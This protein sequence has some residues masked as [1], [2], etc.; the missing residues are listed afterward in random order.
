MRSILDPKSQHKINSAKA[1]TP[2]FSQSV[3][4]LKALSA[5][6]ALEYSTV[7]ARKSL[8]PKFWPWRSQI[9]VSVGSIKIYSWPQQAVKIPF[10]TQRPGDQDELENANKINELFRLADN[11]FA[12]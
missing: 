9:D 1:Q 6:T 5:F 2:E 7:T 3:L 8:W 4:S 12:R 11:K 10:I